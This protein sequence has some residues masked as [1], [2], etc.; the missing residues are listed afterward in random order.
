MDPPLSAPCSSCPKDGR[1]VQ[2]PTLRRQRQVKPGSKGLGASAL[3]MVL[4]KSNHTLLSFVPTA[5]SLGPLP[6]LLAFWA[7]SQVREPLAGAACGLSVLTHWCV[8][9]ACW[10]LPSSSASSLWLPRPALWA[11]M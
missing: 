4:F 2:Q 6:A 1:D 7:W 9:W 5:S 3:T 8:L 11:L 10:D